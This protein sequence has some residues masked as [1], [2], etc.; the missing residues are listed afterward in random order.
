[1][2]IVG[3]LTLVIAVLGWILW[4]ALSGFTRGTFAETGKIAFAAGLLA[5]CIASG[6]QSC[7]VGTGGGGSGGS[8]QHH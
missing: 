4:A 1:M 8:A 6:S 2:A 5:F 3:I 7:S